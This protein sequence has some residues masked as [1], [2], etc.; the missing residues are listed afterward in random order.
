MTA[1]MLDRA[2][3]DFT[4]TTPATVD[5]ANNEYT[6]V[7]E[8]PECE[9]LSKTVETAA[10]E[11]LKIVKELAAAGGIPRRPKYGDRMIWHNQAWMF[12]HPDQAMKLANTGFSPIK[13]KD[14]CLYIVDPVKR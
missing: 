5:Y 9:L 13:I 1:C 14:D 11:L 8:V 12:I 2:A 6:R 3:L 7:Y 4:D 10:V